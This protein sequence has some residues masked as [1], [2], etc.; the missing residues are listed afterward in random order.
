[1]CAC[2]FSKRDSTTVAISAC[3]ILHVDDIPICASVKELGSFRAMI[4]AEFRTGSLMFAGKVSMLFCGL[5]I[6]PQGE[7]ISISQNDY[8][9]NLPEINRGQFF[10]ED[11]L[12]QNENS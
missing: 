2:V 7:S 8:R 5:Q 6:R 10:G 4:S 1:M 3:L 12:Y 11:R 9:D